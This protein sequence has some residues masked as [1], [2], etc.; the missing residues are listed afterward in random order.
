M[1]HITTIEG[2]N[3][4]NVDNP[5]G[6]GSR[7]VNNRD[8]V[9]VVQAMLKYAVA[10]NPYF[11]YTNVF[12]VTGQ[13]DN[14]TILNIRTFQQFVREKL[15]SRVSVDGRIDPAKGLFVS[16]GKRG[17]R[18]RLTWTIGQLNGAALE[19]CFLKGREDYIAD[20][21][22]MYPQVR[23]ILAGNAVGSLRLALA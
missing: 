5:V 2:F 10:N 7:A 3:E 23:A 19:A 22:K 11:A 14:E 12:P 6:A 15:N 1:A 16:S 18:Q 4:I 17:N 21:C 9:L 8:D 20:I 13:M